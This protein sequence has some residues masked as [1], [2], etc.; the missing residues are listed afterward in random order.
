MLDPA[1]RPLDSIAK[2]FLLLGNANM[3]SSLN[4]SFFTAFQPQVTIHGLNPVHLAIANRGYW[5]QSHILHIPDRLGFFSP[6]SPRLQVH[7]GASFFTWS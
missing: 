6:G 3:L 1:P 5:I 4:D 2:N 7:E